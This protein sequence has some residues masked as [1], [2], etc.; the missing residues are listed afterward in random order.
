MNKCSN[1]WKD[2]KCSLTH[3]ML[4]AAIVAVNQL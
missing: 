1:I 3:N 2:I 4:T